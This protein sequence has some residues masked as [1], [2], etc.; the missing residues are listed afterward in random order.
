MASSIYWANISFQLFNLKTYTTAYHFLFLK[1][2][3][4]TNN[5]MN[6]TARHINT[7]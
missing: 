3:I 5:H 4:M 6:L 7:T 1:N 2:D